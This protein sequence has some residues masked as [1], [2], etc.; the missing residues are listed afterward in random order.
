LLIVDDHVAIAESLRVLLSREPD[1]ELTELAHD[2]DRAL[3]I[4]KASRPDVVLM[5][6][7]L[8]RMTGAEATGHV[9]SA[10]PETAVV[11]FSG[12]MTDDELV[13]AVESGIRGYVMKGAPVAEVVSSIRRAAAGEILL[14][15]D[16]L[17]RLLQ[18]G[19]QRARQRAERERH[20]A[21]MTPR[22]REVLLLMAQALELPAI[23]DRLGISAHTAR[24]YVQSI[25][26]KLHRTR[27]WKPSSGRTSSAC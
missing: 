10:S 17:A 16:E 18:H 20:V 26:E 25:L 7:G 15:P 27:S 11:M 14:A 19:R 21:A 22:E 8:P 24:G 4:V 9:L 6:H 12:A 5:D 2:A 1:F 13:T 3:E 23:A